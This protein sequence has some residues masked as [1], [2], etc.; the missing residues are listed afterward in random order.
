[1]GDRREVERLYLFDF[2]LENAME[3]DLTPLHGSQEQ[4]FSFFGYH[5][6]VRN[7]CNTDTHLKSH[8]RVLIEGEHT[9]KS[10]SQGHFQKH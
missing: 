4:R 7:L 9:T 1:M 2:L 6:Q 3:A 5:Q 10:F 8:N